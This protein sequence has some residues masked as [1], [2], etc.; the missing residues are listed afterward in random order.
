MGLLEVEM[1][2]FY[3]QRPNRKY[4]WFSFVGF[5]NS[6]V[7]LRRHAKV[8]IFI[9]MQQRYKNRKNVALM[10]IEFT[11]KLPIE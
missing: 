9:H 10:I 11:T 1:I 4:T 6:C 2:Q 5:N 8:L 7:L 3:V